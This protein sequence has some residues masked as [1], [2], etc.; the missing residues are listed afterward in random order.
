MK[1][2]IA[3]PELET[4]GIT[5]FGITVIAALVLALALGVIVWCATRKKQ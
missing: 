4:F 5:W 1:P 2:I 3:M